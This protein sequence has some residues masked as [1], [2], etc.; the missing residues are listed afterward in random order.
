MGKSMFVSLHAY[1]VID[2]AAA[3][4]S[5]EGWY[6]VSSALSAIAALNG[7]RLFY[8]GI[9]MEGRLGPRELLANFRNAVISGA[10]SFGIQS[11]RDTFLSAPAESNSLSE[12]GKKAPRIIK[13][14]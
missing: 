7:V 11:L 9:R 8:R 14:L 6:Y 5:Q 10:L 12:R 2:R 1:G 3:S 4:S 13:E